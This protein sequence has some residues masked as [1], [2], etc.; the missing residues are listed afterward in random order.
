MKR[1]DEHYGLGSQKDRIAL[2][3]K[4]L[5][6]QEYN[7]PWF[8]FFSGLVLIPGARAG[9]KSDSLNGYAD[10]YFQKALDL[11][12]SHPGKTWL[13]FVE[14]NRFGIAKWATSSLHQLEKIFIT[15]GA[16][17][18]PLISQS[19]LSYV[20]SGKET[21]FVLSD[22]ACYAW[23][24]NFDKHFAWNGVRSI[25]KGLPLKSGEI[26]SGFLLFFRTLRNSWTTQLALI[27]HLFAW[28]SE[29]ILIFIL[30]LFFAITFK[31][32]SHALHSFS[33]R[34]PPQVPPRLK[35]FYSL[36]IFSGFASFGIVPFLWF[37]ALLAWRYYTNR[38]KIIAGICLGV[39]IFL[40]FKT[41]IHDM[42]IQPTY[43]TNTLSLFRKACDEGYYPALDF[44]ITNHI[45][46]NPDDYLAHTSA[47]IYA[48][49]E[50]DLSAADYH[51]RKALEFK[52]NDP[53]ALLTAGNIAYY[54]DNLDKANHFYSTCLNRFPELEASFFNPCL[55]YF[56]EMKIIEGID[57][58]EQAGERNRHKISSFVKKNDDYF[59]GNWPKIRH[60]LQPDYGYKYFWT[61]V[62]PRYSGNWNTTEVRWG[63]KF[64]GFSPRTYMIIT[65]I[66]FIVLLIIG[67][68]LGTPKI[69]SCKLCGV[70]VCRRCLRKGVCT[71]CSEE[72][73]DITDPALL[74][75]MQSSI[76]I[77][78]RRTD[79]IIA[80]I[81]NII[82]PG[83]G[84][85]YHSTKL[86]IADIFRILFTSLTYAS[87][88]WF[89]TSDF[90]YPEYVMHNFAA[91]L[92]IIPIGYHIISIARI[93]TVYTKELKKG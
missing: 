22:S 32:I 45:K 85:L 4:L 71:H 81:L 48:I 23:A 51:I 75:H 59:S 24:A 39:L 92:M 53:V 57:L 74:N 77:K 8:S 30:A 10:S 33:E 1:P 37:N 28:F 19:L 72:M 67:Y 54:T 91:I 69:Y 13:L 12:A 87:Y 52:P 25:L 35:Q 11:A 21:D 62:W 65:S 3:K 2:G 44:A 17:S 68:K 26:S 38:D 63:M 41:R 36:L 15:Q 82:F 83:F 49:K 93:L 16:Q 70:P 64:L 50:E 46:K 27:E 6:F 55:Y 56:G 14:F 88:I 61:T 89:F 42:F 73:T 80:L 47:S 34:F 43:S 31:Y 60:F 29:G 90:N 9:N 79:L 5:K 40:P 76:L 78:R 18:A 7:N 84:S 86:H 66:L 58:I 20:H